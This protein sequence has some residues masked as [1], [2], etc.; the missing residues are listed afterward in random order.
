MYGLSVLYG[1][2]RMPD[3]RRAHP[4]GRMARHGGLGATCN[5]WIWLPGNSQGSVERCDAVVAADH[6]FAIDGRKTRGMM[7][8]PL[9][10]PRAY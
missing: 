5:G 8:Y 6:F 10:P 4:A 2:R 7:F 3:A 9:W 1:K